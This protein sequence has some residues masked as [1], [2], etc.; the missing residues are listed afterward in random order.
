MKTPGSKKILLSF[1]ILLSFVIV[2]VITTFFGSQLFNRSL[3]NVEQNLPKDSVKS[4]SLTS[5]NSFSPRSEE[6]SEIFSNPDKFST[7]SF[8][9]AKE[10]T[11]PPFELEKLQ[12][13]E[14]DLDKV[15]FVG[16]TKIIWETPSRN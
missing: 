12:A 13:N 9:L 10:V 11:L 2:A 16:Y 7:V 3:I 14:I 1:E 6:L 15:N 5:E 8:S 4:T